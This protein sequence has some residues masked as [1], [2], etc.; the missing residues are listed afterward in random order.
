MNENNYCAAHGDELLSSFDWLASVATC[1][2]A[3]LPSI[4]CSSWISS[5]V[6]DVNN[7]FT[8]SYVIVSDRRTTPSSLEMS[9]DGM[10]TSSTPSP[11]I[12]KGKTGLTT[13]V[14]DPVFDVAWILSI[15]K[16]MIKLSKVTFSFSKTFSYYS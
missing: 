13:L 12:E 16:S 2:D 3:L 1:D 11:L 14:S 10:L 4:F 7:T 9:K 5:S 15:V 8:E 6:P